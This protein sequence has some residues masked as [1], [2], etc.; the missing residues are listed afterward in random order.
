MAAMAAEKVEMTLRRTE[1]AFLDRLQAALR[2]ATPP[3]R[4][5]DELLIDSPL[6][7][8]LYLVDRR[9]EL[10]YPRAEGELFEPIA[11]SGA[12][13]DRPD[14]G[15]QLAQREGL[16][17]VVVGSEL[18]PADAVDFLA[19]RGEHDDGHVEAKWSR[20]SD[21]WT[22][23]GDTSVSP[24][25]GRSTPTSSGSGASSKRTPT[26]LSGSSPSTVTVTSSRP[27][28]IL[29]SGVRAAGRPGAGAP[30]CEARR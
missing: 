1:D 12:A 8:R 9:G 23:C 15:E 29:L 5:V 24:P 16:G 10:L 22:R 7:R 25:R 18:K 21:C 6:I 14:P 19:P 13:Q 2:S 4:D 27:C 3:A 30:A 17:H 20:A 28:E 26:A 11:R